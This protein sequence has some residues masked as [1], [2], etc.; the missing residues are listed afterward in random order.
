LHR[1]NVYL[2]NKLEQDH[3]GI[4]NRYRPMQG[5]ESL[6]SAGRFCRAFDEVRNV[7]RVRSLRGQHVSA[8]ISAQPVRSVRS[9][10]AP[11]PDWLPLPR[12]QA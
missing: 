5:L 9:P 1:T 2:N 7:L 10:S 8:D 6:A 12:R 4:K 11:L 3:R